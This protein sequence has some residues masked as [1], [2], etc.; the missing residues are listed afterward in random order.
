MNDQD[1]KSR[2]VRKFKSGLVSAAVWENTIQTDNGPKTVQNIT[3]QRSY[4][5]DTGP[6]KNSDSYTQASLGNLLAVVLQALVSCSTEEP[7]DIPI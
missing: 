6:W 3:F 7:D 4:R 5:D 1:K 2:P